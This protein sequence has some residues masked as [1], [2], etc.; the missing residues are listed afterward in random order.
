MDSRCV[1]VWQGNGISLTLL[2]AHSLKPVLLPRNL[3]TANTEPGYY[4]QASRMEKKFFPALELPVHRGRDH[5][6]VWWVGQLRENA[7]GYPHWPVLQVVKLVSRRSS[8][9]PY[10]PVPIDSEH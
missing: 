7:V 8:P 10:R 4:G 2:A 9:V 3:P 1:Y 6:H 5:G